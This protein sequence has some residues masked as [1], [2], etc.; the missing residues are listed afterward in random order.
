MLDAILKS[1]FYQLDIGVN[2][3]WMMTTNEKIDAKI[4]AARRARIAR[5][6]E[7]FLFLS[8]CALLLMTIILKVKS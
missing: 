5:E 6:F 7:L 2:R 8:A 1:Q 4:R 3:G